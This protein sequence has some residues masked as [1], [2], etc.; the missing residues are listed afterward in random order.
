MVRLV[1]WDA[2]VPILM[3]LQWLKAFLS[4]TDQECRGHFTLQRTS[5]AESVS[6]YNGPAMQK[7][8]LPTTDQQC[9]KRLSL[10]RTSN[11]ESVSPYNGPAIQKTFLPTT[12]QQCR[13]RFFLQ[14]T[15]N[16]ESVSPYNGPAMQKAFLPTT[17]QQCRKR[18]SLQR[19]SNAE[20]VS[21]YN[22]PAMQKAFLPTTDQQCRKRFSLQRTSNAESV[23]PY[24]GPAMQKAFPCHGII[25]GANIPPLQ[26]ALYRLRKPILH[27]HGAIWPLGLMDG[28][29]CIYDICIYI[30]HH[31]WNRNGLK[32]YNI[33]SNDI[34][35]SVS[36]W[37]IFHCYFNFALRWAKSWQTW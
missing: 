2:I 7:A 17:D 23:S 15:S 8:F 20:S 27:G 3:S 9:R 1:I 30:Y 13:K 22:G 24:N 37:R 33:F 34:M 12:D 4:T 5:N 21:P 26:I 32:K 11:A 19:T 29:I 31:M 28:L 14:R 25:M 18:F 10:Q 36:V 6:P 35:G 16:A